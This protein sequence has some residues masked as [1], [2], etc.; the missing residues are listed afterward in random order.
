MSSSWRLEYGKWIY[1]WWGFSS[2]AYRIL[3]FFVLGGKEETL[4]DEAVKALSLSPGDT[5]LDLCCGNGSNLQYLESHV[6]PQGRILALDY[7]E[8]MLKAAQET[9]SKR[10]WKNIEFHQGDAAEK[11]YDPNSLDGAICTLALTAVPNHTQ[12]IEQIRTG[13]KPGKKF[14]VMDSKGFDGLLSIFNPIIRLIFLLLTNWDSHKDIVGELKRTFGR[15][16]VRTVGLYNSG[17]TY[18]V[19]A[20]T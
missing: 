5:A 7:S 10:S 17:S 15:D 20:N 13:L 18:I 6:G 16:N 4:R 14:V 1:N 2:I 8:G 3:M 11:F 9:A 19:E 12:A